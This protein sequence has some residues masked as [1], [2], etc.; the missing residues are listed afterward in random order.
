LFSLEAEADITKKL[1]ARNRILRSVARMPG[2][3]VSVRS[4]NKAVTTMSQGGEVMVTMRPEVSADRWVRGE[5]VT[6]R[7]QEDEAMFTRGPGAE[8]VNIWR[9]RG[10]VMFV[11]V[12]GIEV[13]RPGAQAST[14]RR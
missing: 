13:W 14:L 11:R 6:T 4:G 9:P 12:P 2:G 7:T 3:E 1:G 5:A 10:E 8:V